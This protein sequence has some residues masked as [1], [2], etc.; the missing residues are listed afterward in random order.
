[1]RSLKMVDKPVVSSF[2]GI[3]YQFSTTA[4]ALFLKGDPHN[5]A[6]ADTPSGL[7]TLSG[8][9]LDDLVDGTEVTG[10][11][12]SGPNFGGVGNDGG[13][14]L[15]RPIKAGAYELSWTDG[16]F[17]TTDG[18][19]AGGSARFAGGVDGLVVQHGF[20]SKG[21][22][23]LDGTQVDDTADFAAKLYRAGAT[24][25]KLITSDANDVVVAGTGTVRLIYNAL[26]S[27]GQDLVLG[28]GADD[29]IELGD[30]LGFAIERTNDDK[31]VWKQGPGLVHADG[32][33]GAVYLETDGILSSSDIFAGNSATLDTLRDRLDVSGMVQ[34]D[35]LLILARDVNGSGGALYYFTEIVDNGQI[36][37]GELGVIALFADGVPEMAQIGLVGVPD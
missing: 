27:G 21:E 23:D 13:L 28:F 16:T 10:D 34:D 35:G 25:T 11:Y 19:L 7:L 4:T 1:M 8:L 17:A 20:T 6:Q 36:D 12:T 9:T 5:V 15:S 30:E 26:N 22:Q 14:R 2:D 31:I 29:R 24:P 3:D 32:N 18:T 33:T 37:A